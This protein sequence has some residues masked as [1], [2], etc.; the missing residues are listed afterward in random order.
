MTPVLTIN[1]ALDNEQLQARG[2][3]VEADGLPQFAPPY[4][5]SDY[6]IFRRP[7]C[8]PAAGQDSDDI[9][10]EAGYDGAAVAALRAQGII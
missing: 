4:K 8:A 1:E 9:L 6:D 7:H 10:R 3:V 5:L 2:M